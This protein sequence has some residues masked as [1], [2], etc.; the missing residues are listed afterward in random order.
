MCFPN[1][2]WSNKNIC[3]SSNSLKVKLERALIKT[4]IALIIAKTSCTPTLIA[5]IPPSIML[6]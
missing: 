6:A 1:Q 5:Y 3:S 2:R 4:A